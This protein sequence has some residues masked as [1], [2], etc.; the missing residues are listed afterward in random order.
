MHVGAYSKRYELP[1]Y[2][3]AI[4]VRHRDLPDP[5]NIQNHYNSRWKLKDSEMNSSYIYPMESQYKSSFNEDSAKQINYERMSKSLVF[6][7]NRGEK[8]NNNGPS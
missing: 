6:D 7:D 4:N 5:E 8:G 2:S 1:N 3:T